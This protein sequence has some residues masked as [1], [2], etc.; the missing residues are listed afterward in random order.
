MVM[1]LQHVPNSYKIIIAD[2]DYGKSLLAWGWVVHFELFTAHIM[3]MRLQHVPNYYYCIDINEC[4]SAPDRDSICPR[5][6]FC[7]NTF[8]T[9]NCICINGTRMDEGGSCTGMIII[10]CH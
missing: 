10:P 8:G 1:R 9:Y 3:G 6:S 5:S 7:V 2:I 4:E